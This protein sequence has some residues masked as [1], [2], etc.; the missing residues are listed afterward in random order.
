MFLGRLS[1]HDSN[2]HSVTSKYD[3]R[4]PEPSVHSTP[5]CPAAPWT[6]VF[7]H[8]RPEPLCPYI[9]DVNSCVL[10]SA[11]STSVSLHQ[12]RQPLCPYIS[13]L[14]CSVLTSATWTPVS[15]HQR[16][17]LLCP[18]INDVNLCVLTSATSTSV[19]LRQR[20]AAVDLAPLRHSSAL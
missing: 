20:G 5:S 2:L 10:T 9:S 19:S 14:N 7:L 16:P 17:E 3:H 8:Q 15:L 6:S 13:D 18:D 12:R 11:T 1:A 4:L